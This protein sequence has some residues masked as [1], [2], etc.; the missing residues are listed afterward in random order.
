MIIAVFAGFISALFA[1]IIVKKTGNLA[2]YLLA[3][4]PLTLFVYFAGFIF[5]VDDGATYNFYYD[6]ASDKFKLT[7]YLDGLSLIFALLIS[8]IGTF[9]I[10]YAGGYLK[11]HQNLGRFIGFLLAF[12]GSMLGLVLADNIM[13]LF[14]FW[15]MTSITSFMLIGFDNHR[16][17]SRRSAIQALVVTGLGGLS[18]LAGLFVLAH[19]GYTQ[20]GAPI[21]ELSTFLNADISIID[22]D[23]YWVALILILGGAFTKSAQVPFHFWL[24][25]AMEAPTPVSAYL[26]SATMVKA[27]VYL[28]M[29]LQPVMGGHELWMT[30]LPLFGAATL[31]TGTLLAVRQKDLKLM[32]AYTTV[33]SLGLL[34]LLIGT[35]YKAAILG[36]IAY[37]VAH[38]LFKGC[39]FM[40]AGAIDHE[41]GTRD[42]T[43]LGGLRKLMP[44][45]FAAACLAAISMAGIIPAIGFLAKEEMYAGLLGYGNMALLGAV[46]IGNAFMMVVG[47]AIAIKPFL[48]KEVKAAK[49][50]NLIHEAPISLLAGPIVLAVLG[51]LSGLLCSYCF[52]DKFLNPAAMAVYGKEFTFAWKLWHGF[53]TPL[54]LSLLTIALGLLIF[55]KIDLVRNILSKVFSEK[56]WGPDKG[57]DQFISGLVRFSFKITTKIQ[58]GEMRRYL[59]VSFAIVA[60]A[61]AYPLIDNGVVPEFPDFSVLTFYELAVLAIAFVGVVL[62]VRAKTRLDAILSLGAQGFAV[63]LIFMLFGAPDLSFTQFMIETLSVVILAL[64]LTRLTLNK[65]DHRGLRDNIIDLSIATVIGVSLMVA[66]LAVTQMPFNN[67]LSAFFAEYSKPIAHG[68]NIVNVIIVDYRGMDTFGEIAVV[69]AAGVSILA[70]IRLKSW[71]IRSDQYDDE[72]LL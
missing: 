49:A 58:N 69:F 15:E 64:V 22:H 56:R 31:I 38:S 36:A 20:T 3:L 8:G 70:L 4:V 68:R 65:G 21:Y 28:L 13:T 54:F 71:K 5:T 10:I 27:G 7:F 60:F 17:A 47:V 6:W 66:L 52:G 14:V 19:M 16:T 23:F 33:A 43:K 1:P 55:W 29:R 26:H 50:V 63:A 12:M 25:N 59:A 37:L 61:M 32:L 44:W 40:V 48:G 9:V 24:P 46:I 42:I 67:E 72:D 34:V 39:L 11:G 51:I 45:T 30:I 62:V 57:F 53:K 35:S 41:A 2:A 18:L